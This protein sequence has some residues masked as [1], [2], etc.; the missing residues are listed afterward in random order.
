ME[1][2]EDGVEGEE[3]EEEEEEEEEEGGER[4]EGEKGEG[5]G[6]GWGWGGKVMEVWWEGGERRKV[7]AEGER[8]GEEGEEG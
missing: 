7:A 1:W 8:K 3:R 5:E 2:K 4:G 6:W